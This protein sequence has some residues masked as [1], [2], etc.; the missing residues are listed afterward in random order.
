MTRFP[1]AA[2]L[3]AS[4]FAALLL[5]HPAPA[6]VPSTMSYQGLLTDGAGTPVADGVYDLTLRLYD[7][8]SD[9]APLWTE[10]QSAVP[11]ARG[12]FSISLGSVV[13]LTLP[14]DQPYWLGTSIDP[15]AELAP[16]TPLT[17]SP[18]ALSVRMPLPAGSVDA[19]VLLD[20]PGIA[21]SIY[22]GTYSVIGN[23]NQNPAI[24]S[25]DL[26][27]TITTPGPG[28]VM[29]SAAG[30]ITF[31]N[32][33]GYEYVEYQISET[34]GLS[35]PI[36]V[37]AQAGYVQ[38]C[39]FGAAPNA[40]YYDFPMSCQRVFYKPVAGPYRFSFLTARLGSYTPQATVTN[41]SLTAT[42]FPSSYGTVATAATAPSASML[43][44]APA[45]L[46]AAGAEVPGLA[47]PPGERQP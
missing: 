44:P 16:R 43:P 47:P 31:S 25:G 24:L 39:G 11:V 1:R 45:L 4:C 29:L 20:E 32:V 14:F 30:Y 12:I 17:S 8:P 37:A 9:G 27:V 10:T 46:P 13:P 2:L 35:A 22:P 15:D 41:L 5:A 28:Y 3:V 42:Y 33:T 26:S 6:E 18:Y 23:A 21:Q 36:T 38:F 7:V 40:N 19:Q 34:T